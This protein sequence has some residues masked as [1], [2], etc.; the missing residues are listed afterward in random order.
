MLLVNPVFI[1]LSAGA[2]PAGTTAKE[3]YDAKVLYDSAFNPDNGEKQNIFGRMSFQ[4]PGG[5]V[6]T[7]ILMVYYR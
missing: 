2:V 1:Q 4:L 6:L 5:M 3:L 7:G